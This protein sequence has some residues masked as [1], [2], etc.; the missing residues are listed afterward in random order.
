MKSGEWQLVAGGT[1]RAICEVHLRPSLSINCR[2]FT[3]I[4]L[5]VTI[6]VIAILAA[7]LLPTLGQSK[8]SAWC[9]ECASNLRQMGMATELYWG[10]NNGSCFKR[11]DPATPGGQN[12]WFGWLGAGASGHRPFDLS[13]GKL[14]PYL[15]SS[16]VR[17]CPAMDYKSPEFMLKGTNVISSYGCNTYVFVAP[18]QQPIKASQIIHP[19]RTALFADTAQVDDFLPPA[20]P[21]HPMFEEFYYVDTNTS[22]P[23]GQ[24]RHDQMANV[25]FGDGHVNLEKPVPGSIDQRLPKQYIGRLPSEILT[26]Q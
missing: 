18:T 12:W 5:L 25:V 14:Y 21:S 22:Y 9:T 2:A 16:N 24:F 20:S 3:L 23:N 26:L 17:L 7:M 1:N 15:S 11:A 19:T 4:E 13:K 8:Q 10:D 6:A